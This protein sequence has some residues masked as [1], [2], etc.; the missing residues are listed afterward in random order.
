MLNYEFFDKIHGYIICGFK[1]H[2]D[3]KNRKCVEN[4][5]GFYTL[6][7]PDFTIESNSDSGHLK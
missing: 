3:H 5:Y 7:L 1:K 4:D 2:I 6:E